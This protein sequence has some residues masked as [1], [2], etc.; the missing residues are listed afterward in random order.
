[1]NLLGPVKDIMTTQVVT[2][3]P[4]ATMHRVE[5]IFR[6]HP[7]HHLP[8]ED[9]GKLIGMISKSDF[10]FFKRGFNDQTTDQRLDLFRLK[11]WKAKDV[12]VTKLAKMDPNQRIDV[13]LEL[14]QLNLFHAIPIVEEDKLLGIVTPH[15]VIH[16]IMEDRSITNQYSSK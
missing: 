16:H 4:E 2:V 9:Q 10:L 14:F 1:M 3:E 12:M 11:V 13:A 15:D 6:E 7:F 5:K 8:V